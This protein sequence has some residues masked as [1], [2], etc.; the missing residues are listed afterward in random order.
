[1]QCRSF[2]LRRRPLLANME[3]AAAS[4]DG[5]GAGFVPFFLRGVLLLARNTIARTAKAAAGRTASCQVE[6]VKDYFYHKDN[7]S[8]GKYWMVRYSID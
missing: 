2:V 4:L 3:S 8:N 5:G 1:M 6:E 7:W